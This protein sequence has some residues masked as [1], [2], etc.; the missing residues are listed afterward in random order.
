MA[1]LRRCAVFCAA[2]AS[3]P[4]GPASPPGQLARLL[5]FDDTGTHRYPE[6]LLSWTG[7]IGPKTW[8]PV[9]DIN[10]VSFQQ[11]NQFGGEPF[12]LL[13]DPSTFGITGRR[14]GD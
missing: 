12:V 14:K 5:P 10:Q 7:Q 6:P 1:R 4:A 11:P 3:P 13:S 9:P 8:Y 2:D